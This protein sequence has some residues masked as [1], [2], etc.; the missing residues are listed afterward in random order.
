MTYITTYRSPLGLLTLSSDSLS[1]N[2]LWIEGQKYHGQ[3][4][5]QAIKKDLPIF[6]EAKTWLERYFAGEKP[7][8][9]EL[10][11]AP[12]GSEFRRKVWA[13][14]REIPYGQI[15]SYG[16]IAKQLAAS[17][18]LNRMSSQAVGGAVGHNPIS[19]IVPCHRV[20]G[21]NGDLTGYAGGLDL[22]IKLLE[23]EGVDMSKLFRPKK[24]TAL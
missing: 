19:I 18:N 4:N 14:L 20:V 13:I 9:A 22:K 16:A 5:N 21:S 17:M 23:L 10:S 7:Q 15:V 2:G 1:L 3:N 8:V 11:L 6:D 24:G 12:L